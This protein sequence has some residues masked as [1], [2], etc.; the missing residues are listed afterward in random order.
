M[1]VFIEWQTL[2]LYT[3][4]PPTHVTSRGN[5]LA[6]WRSQ[7]HRIHNS[8]AHCA[9]W[10]SQNHRISH[11]KCNADTWH[12]HTHRKS[13]DHKHERKEKYPVAGVRTQ[14]G[15][16]CHLTTKPR[17]PQD[18]SG[19]VGTIYTLHPQTSLRPQHNFTA[20]H[21]PFASSWIWV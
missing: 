6:T 3:L 14:G 10:H 19:V 21:R 4:A 17:R 20:Q 13:H 15:K 7:S 1:K 9:T 18:K 16:T 12:Y 5:H 11:S 2:C 8:H